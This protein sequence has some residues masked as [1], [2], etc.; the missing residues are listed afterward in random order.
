MTHIVQRVGPPV[1]VDTVVSHEGRR[2]RACESEHRRN[3]EAR[4]RPSPNLEGRPKEHQGA[5]RRPGGEWLEAERDG[6]AA[7]CS[8]TNLISEVLGVALSG[9]AD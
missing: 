3:H 5:Q 8:V 2:H 9:A 1:C 4:H 7:D 6:L